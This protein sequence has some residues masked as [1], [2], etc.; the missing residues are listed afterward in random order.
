MIVNDAPGTTRDSIFIPLERFD[1]HYTLIDTAGVRRRKKVTDTPEKFSVVKTLKTIGAM[2]VLYT[3]NK[4]TPRAIFV[5]DLHLF[6]DLFC[7]VAKA[8]SD[9]CHK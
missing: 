3:I 7:N 1:K 4:R 8:V 9:R 6:Q 2:V 5:Q